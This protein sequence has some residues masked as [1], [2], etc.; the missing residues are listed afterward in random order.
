MNID[1]NYALNLISIKKQTSSEQ[2]KLAKQMLANDPS[3]HNEELVKKITEAAQRLVVPAD[4]LPL[5]EWPD[6]RTFDGE[7]WFCV[8]TAVEVD[9]DVSKRA[10]VII[11]A[12]G[13]AYI[14]MHGLYTCEEVEKPFL[15]FWTKK[16]RKVTPANKDRL[17]FCLPKP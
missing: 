11:T 1:T 17:F 8:E 15:F 5:P 6:P 2:V 10:Q 3:P 9:S 16:H 14:N 13:F 7:N 4:T 12:M